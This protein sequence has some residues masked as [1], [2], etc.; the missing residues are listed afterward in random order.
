MLSGST[1]EASNALEPRHPIVRELPTGTLTL[2]LENCDSDYSELL[3]FAARANQRRSFLFLSKVL[4]KHY[5]ARPRAM[6]ATHASLAKLVEAEPAPVVF[7]GM[8]ETATGLGQGVFEAWLSQNPGREALYLQTTRYRVADVP[9]VTFEER[10]S[11]APRVFLHVPRTP[12]HPEI[13]RT[14]A[15]VVLVDDELSTGNTFVNLVAALRPL[16]PALRSVHVATIC[17]FM[18]TA[19]RSALPGLMGLPC[20]VGARLVGRWEF[21]CNGRGIAPTEAAQCVEGEE[22]RVPE[23]GFGRTGRTTPV[24]L[25]PEAA[26]RLAAESVRGGTLVLGSGEFMHAAFVLGRALEQRGIDVRVQATTR[27]PILRWGHVRHAICLPDPYGEGIPNF[28]YNVG[29]D[30]YARILLCHELEPNQALNAT[31]RLL[32]A[33]LLRFQRDHVE[34]NPVR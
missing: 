32:G 4:G 9:T 12:G 8:A 10:H 24:Q 33:R 15:T 5:P 11:H 2:E 25:Q 27:S 1:A 13:L 26:D 17:D 30:Q 22:V 31:A 28:L 29:R 14:A 7:I 16:M 34:E 23:T 21:H 3:G 6:G 20:S 18:G 19:R